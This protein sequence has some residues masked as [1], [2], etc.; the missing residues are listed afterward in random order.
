MIIIRYSEAV[1]RSIYAEIASYKHLRSK[2]YEK[3]MIRQRSMYVCEYVTSY[4]T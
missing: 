2:S 1:A 3:N 4:I